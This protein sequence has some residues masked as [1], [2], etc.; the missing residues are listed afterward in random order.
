VNPL[1]E[2]EYDV[3]EDENPR[4]NTYRKLVFQGDILKGLVMLNRIEKGGILLSM[5]QNQMPINVEK[6]KL[7][8]PGF[9]FSQLLP[10]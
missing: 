3:L 10:G 1:P 4:R 7:F 8:D 2:E 9:D 6:E 5:I